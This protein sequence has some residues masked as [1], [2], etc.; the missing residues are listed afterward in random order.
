MADIGDVQR[1]EA[2]YREQLDRLSDAPIDDRDR[3]QIHT[4]VRRR[5]RSVYISKSGVGC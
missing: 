3:H 5:T 2:T 1:F 4:L